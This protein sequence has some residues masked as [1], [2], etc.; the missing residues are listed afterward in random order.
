MIPNE[1]GLQN[2]RNLRRCAESMP[3]LLCTGLLK[4]DEAGM[5]LQQG[6]IDI[7]RKPVSHE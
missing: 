1:E 5:L 3:I 4:T 6:N 2:I 7:L